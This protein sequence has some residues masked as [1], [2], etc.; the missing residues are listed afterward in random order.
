MDD[1]AFILVL[2]AGGGGPVITGLLSWWIKG[3]LAD[4]KKISPLE[5]EVK[6]LCSKIDTFGGE[7][8][9]IVDYVNKNNKDI[10]LLQQSDKTQ[11]KNIDTL[12]ENFRTQKL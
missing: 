11:W 6:A 8:K 9:H 7:L 3:M 10:A 5:K 1:K 12:S 4:I 2:L